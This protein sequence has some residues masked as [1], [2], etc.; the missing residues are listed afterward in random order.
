[1][2]TL[3][4]THFALPEQG[5]LERDPETIFSH[6]MPGAADEA[7]LAETVE[8]DLSAARTADGISV[9]VRVTN[10]G[11]GHHVPTDSPLRQV[12]LVVQ[13]TDAAGQSLAL[14]EGPVLPDW[15]GDLADVPGVYYARIL[16]ELWTEI[17][18]TGA[19]WMPTREVEDTRLPAL[20]SDTAQ[21]TFAASENTVTVKAQLVFRRAFYDLMQQK[22]WDTPDILM[23]QAQ[24][25]VANTSTQ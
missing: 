19:Y 12:L 24:V 7:L 1:M 6:R 25:S 21:F 13:A 5:G 16:E 23:E 4:V 9:T 15:A 10:T 2:P 20:A 14:V 22:G 8:L 17:Q 18:P 3:G 11:A